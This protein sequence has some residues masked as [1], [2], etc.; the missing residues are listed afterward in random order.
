MSG[1]A[2]V[3]FR[4]FLHNLHLPDEAI[5][6]HRKTNHLAPK[7][8][9]RHE[10]YIH[11]VYFNRIDILNSIHESCRV[12]VVND[13]DSFPARPLA[14]FLMPAVFACLLFIIGEL[15]SAAC[16]ILCRIEMF[17]ARHDNKH[18]L[19]NLLATFSS[20]V[21]F[22]EPVLHFSPR[23]FGTFGQMFPFEMFPNFFVFSN[24]VDTERLSILLPVCFCYIPQHSKG[25]HTIFLLKDFYI[26][27][28]IRNNGKFLL[29]SNNPIR[30]LLLVAYLALFSVGK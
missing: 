7:C 15:P 26:T 3:P 14:P 19:L 21:F 17:R 6:K 20:A 11:C 25:K 18:C 12:H 28:T 8:L 4:N 9:I 27:I 2:L 23:Y 1:T 30:N 13:K 16:L 22:F 29:Y 24:F 5:G 10:P